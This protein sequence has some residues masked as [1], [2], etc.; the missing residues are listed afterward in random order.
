MSWSKRVELIVSNGIALHEQGVNNW[1]L[2][3]RQALVALNKFE[4]E[5]ISVL[6]GDVY[7]LNNNEPESNYDSWYCDK[8]PGESSDD[9]MVRSVN[10]ARAYIFNYNSPNKRQELFVLVVE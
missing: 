10:K 5:K 8:E 6:G 9:Y 1:A 7:E 3:K 4:N 2:P